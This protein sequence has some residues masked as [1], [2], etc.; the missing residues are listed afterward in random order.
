MADAASGE[1][2]ILVGTHALLSEGV[3]FRSLGLAV[4][5]E[6]HRFGVRQR[7]TVLEKGLTPHVLAMSGAPAGWRRQ[8]G[9]LRLDALLPR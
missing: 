5:D 8:H 1:T 7:L 4:I 3:V 2:D 6:Q 9:R